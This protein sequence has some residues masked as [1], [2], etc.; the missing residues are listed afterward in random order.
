MHSFLVIVSG[1]LLVCRARGSIL[2][3]EDCRYDVDADMPTY[4]AFCKTCPHSVW[5]NKADDACTDGYEKTKAGGCYLG[6]KNAPMTL[7][8]C[9]WNCKWVGKQS[10]DYG[11][12]CNK[13]TSCHDV[14]CV[15]SEW[16]AW[17]TCTR[18]NGT[19]LTCDP[20]S[21]KIIGIQ[22]R[23]RSVD[24][25]P[26]FD[27]AICGVA[28]DSRLCNSHDCEVW[29]EEFGAWSDW[30]A[31]KQTGN[32][33]LSSKCKGKKSRNRDV[34]D[35]ATCT[36]SHTETEKVLCNFSTCSPQGR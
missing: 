30:G 2:V 29:C 12:G 6:G 32:A 36:Y 17:T 3:G 21:P 7:P 8:G 5:K 20:S 24:T 34:N 28:R 16:S 22:T 18:S 10:V 26:E 25:P 1:A 4:R 15:M 9:A 11:C 14:D 13:G 19:P 27:G 23:S 33:A 35:P 31:C